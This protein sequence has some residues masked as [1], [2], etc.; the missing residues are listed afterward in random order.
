[1][2]AGG[3]LHTF[4]L[5]FE[6]Q[7]LPSWISLQL[8][9]ERREGESSAKDLSVRHSSTLDRLK[10]FSFSMY[11]LELGTLSC[12]LQRRSTNTVLSVRRRRKE[13][14]VGIGQR[15]FPLRWTSVP[16]TGLCTWRSTDRVNEVSCQLRWQAWATWLALSFKV[17]T[18]L[19]LSLCPALSTTSHY[20][21]SFYCT[22]WKIAWL[23]IAWD[24]KLLEKIY[25]FSFVSAQGLTYCRYSI[26][27]ISERMALRMPGIF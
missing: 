8:V 9:L 4:L 23:K 1:M 20:P 14:A 24:Y 13:L 16:W 25:H 26:N 27:L 11:G 12:T 3:A 7:Q 10:I 2:P 15:R 5:Y 18:Q 19:T 17:N 22:V 6:P 21:K